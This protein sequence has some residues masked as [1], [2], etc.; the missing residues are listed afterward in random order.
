MQRP[1]H[2]MQ[3][4]KVDLIYFN[5]GGGHRASA[6][7]LQEV[8]RDQQR[9]WDVR[10]GQPLGG[11]R[12]RW[13]LSQ[14][15]R[16]RSRGVLQPPA[17]SR[18]DTRSGSGAAAAAG[19]DSAVPS[20]AEAHAGAALAAHRTRPGRLA[21][22][23]LQPR[24]VRVGLRD[25]SGHSVR[26]GD[27]R[28]G[29]PAAPFLDRAGT[30]AAC[31]VRN[32]PR[33]GTG[34]G[35]RCRRRADLADLRD[36]APASFYRALGMDRDAEL[37]DLGLDPNRPTGV[38]MFGGQGSM[39]MLRIA[40]QLDDVQLIFLCG[41]NDVLAGKLRRM[42]RAAG[43]GVIGL[44]VEHRTLHEAGRFLHREARPRM[45]QRSTAPSGC[46]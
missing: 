20:D 25:A 33:G 23:E 3:M 12:Q 22:A 31:R 29:G 40:K 46:R 4:R 43:H 16:I 24:A 17:R 2:A 44:H 13:Q 39:Q 32:P 45:P 9:P 26:D 34:P 6:M 28:H 27:D 41:H 1:Q 18:L 19:P 15:A 14:A 11:P 30:A 10:P 36:D 37:R 21:R 42:R 5:A 7:A 8:I 35:R 38:V